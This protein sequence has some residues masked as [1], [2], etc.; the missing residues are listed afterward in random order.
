MKEKKRVL[1]KHHNNSFLLGCCLA[2][3]SFSCVLPILSLSTYCLSD[4]RKGSIHTHQRYDLGDWRRTDG[5]S[6]LPLSLSALCVYTKAADNYT[7]DERIFEA[8][9][10]LYISFFL[11]SPLSCSSF[12]LSLTHCMSANA[13]DPL[14]MKWV[15]NNLATNPTRLLF[16]L[17]FVVQ[18]LF[19]FFTLL[20]YFC[21]PIIYLSSESAISRQQQK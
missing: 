5:P 10:R 21:R 19:F 14:V 17:S 1:L 4:R 20:N 12:S 6:P 15:D 7:S 2:G 8:E 18:R 3:P 9:P 13:D 11:S 16:I